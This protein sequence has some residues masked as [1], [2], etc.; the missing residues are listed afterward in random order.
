MACSVQFE[1][2]PADRFFELGLSYC[3]GEEAVQDLIQAHKWLN[4]AAIAGSEE[5]RRLRAEISRDM[6]PAQI[7]VAQRLAR[8]HIAS[9]TI[10]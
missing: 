7:A 3:S 5:A 4:L 6:S 1:T 8:E 10:H 2:Q 9:Q